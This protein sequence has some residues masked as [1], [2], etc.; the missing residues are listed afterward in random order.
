MQVMVSCTHTHCGPHTRTLPS[1]ADRLD[2][3]Y[4][5]TLID[6]CHMLYERTYPDHSQWPENNYLPMVSFENRR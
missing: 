4:L 2:T 1:C 5:E 3:G 6:R